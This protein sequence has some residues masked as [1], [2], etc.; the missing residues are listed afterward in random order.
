[1]IIV[2]MLRCLCRIDRH[3]DCDVMILTDSVDVVVNDDVLMMMVVVVMMM[4]VKMA[5][6]DDDGDG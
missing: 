5:M 6:V 1:M 2:M 4:V 3:D